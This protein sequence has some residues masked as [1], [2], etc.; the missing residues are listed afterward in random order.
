MSRRIAG[1][2]IIATSLSAVVAAEDAPS[3]KV[4]ARVQ[5]WYEAVQRAAADGGTANDFLLRRAYVSLTGTLPFKVSLFAHVSGDRIGQQG[6]DNPGLG[7]GTGLAVRDAWIAWE[8]D[9]SFRV[10]LGRMYVPFTRALGTESGFMLLTVDM[11]SSQGGTRGPLFYASKVGRDD[12]VVLWGTPLEGRLQ[13]RFGV[14]EGVEG[15]GNPSDSLRFSGRLAVNLLEPETAWFNRGTYLG[16]KRVLAI[17]VGFDRQDNLV[18]SSVGSFDSRSWT[19]DVFLDYP[20]RRG[21]VTVEGAFT[22][23]DGLTQ[24]LAF[25]GL[26]PGA[27]LRIGYV[28]AGYLVPRPL[29]K[30][31]LQLYGRL[32][33]IDSA[34]GADTS[35]PAVGANYLLRGQDLKATLDCSWLDRPA[36]A[37]VRV[38]TFQLQVGF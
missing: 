36:A 13:Y 35:S 33:K 6:L 17:G 30:G 18:T 3:F 32:E 5:A 25:S 4:G 8:P 15:A 19:A 27:D 9:P 12:G 37:A 24:T 26:S 31:R 38:V 2:A 34:G 21:A 16:A 28:Q 23:V 10:Q 14:M 29:G 7:L 20:L 11:P 22:D 1:L